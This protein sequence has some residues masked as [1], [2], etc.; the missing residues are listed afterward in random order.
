MVVVVVQGFSYYSELSMKIAAEVEEKML[1]VVV[2]VQSFSCYSELPM[3]TAAEVEA[4]E[5]EEE[6]ENE[7]KAEWVL[8]LSQW[9]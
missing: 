8:L 3:K 2:V 4:E 5:E 7:L 9:C 6:E 1:M